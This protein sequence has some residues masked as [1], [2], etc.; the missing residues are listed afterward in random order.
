MAG[1]APGLRFPAQPIDLAKFCPTDPTKVPMRRCT[2]QGYCKICSAEYTEWRFRPRSADV[3]LKV[4]TKK[5]VLCLRCA[6]EKDVCQVRL[7]DMSVLL[8]VLSLSL[9]SPL[10]P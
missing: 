6:K 10:C 8:L 7:F 5:T 1:W 3:R 4:R 9:S 2:F